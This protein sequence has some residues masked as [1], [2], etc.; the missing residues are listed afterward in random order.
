MAAMK[1]AGQIFK[2]ARLKKDLTQVEL[3]KKAGVYPNTYSKI[4]RDEQEPSFATAKKL[5]KV[6]DIDISDIPA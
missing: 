5:A 4:E 3:A 1:T 6:L 2:D